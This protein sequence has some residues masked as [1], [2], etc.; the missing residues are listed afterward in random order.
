[1]VPRSRLLQALIALFLFVWSSAAAQTVVLH[2]DFDQ[3]TVGELP[4]TDL[5][6]SPDGDYLATFTGGGTITVQTEYSDLVQQPVVLQRTSSSSFGIQFWLDPDLRD[7]QVYTVR[8]NSLL[9]QFA[10]FFYVNFSS[11]NR[12]TMGSVEFRSSGQ[13]TANGSGNVLASTYAPMTAQEIEV[14]LDIA[15]KTMDVMIDGVPDPN[16][17]DLRHYQTGGNGL[18]FVGLSFGL[19]DTYTVAFDDLHVTGIG[20]VGVANER[21]SWGALK[22]TY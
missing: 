15:N 19:L 5:S 9:S 6:G 11:P 4:A 14:Q 18:R 13:M 8:W 17:Q 10:Q 1:M 21:R 3:D 12:Q 7:C 2:A 22:A 20:C 16:G